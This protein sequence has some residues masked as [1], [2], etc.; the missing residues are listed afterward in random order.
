MDR[1]EA[2]NKFVDILMPINVGAADLLCMDPIGKWLV[3]RKASDYHNKY[4]AFWMFE[5]YQ[6]EFWSVY[7]NRSYVRRKLPE[8]F[9][10]P[11]TGNEEFLVYA[12]MVVEYLKEEDYDTVEGLRFMAEVHAVW[13]RTCPQEFMDEYLGRKNVSEADIKKALKRLMEHN[14]SLS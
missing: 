10:G 1:T 7:N 4:T 9:D 8:G 14:A 3:Y 2:L 6:D 12:D 11:K 5:L 13:A